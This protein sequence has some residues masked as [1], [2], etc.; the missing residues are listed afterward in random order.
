MALLSLF[1]REEAIDWYERAVRSFASAGNASKAAEASLSLAYVHLWNADSRSARAAL[2]RAL[3]VIGAKPSFLLH[4]IL[5]TRSTCF[6]VGGEIEAASSALAKAKQVE[7]ALPERPD[8]GLALMTEARILYELGRIEDAEICGREAI[9]RFKA[10]GDLW[11]QVEVFEVSIAACYMGRIGRRNYCCARL[12]LWRS[13]LAM[14][15][16]NGSTS[17]AARGY[18]WRWEISTGRFALRG[19]RRL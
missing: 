11:N 9:R 15:A 14:A 8:D 1:R 3:E 16:R 17:L 13:E 4:R 2:D 7:E 10:A 6:G 12:F 18:G 5:M 19:R